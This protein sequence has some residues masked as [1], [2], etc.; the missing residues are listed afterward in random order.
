MN[1]TFDSTNFDRALRELARETRKSTAQI[2]REQAGLLAMDLMRAYPPFGGFLQKE[3]FAAQRRVGDAAT[4]KQIRSVYGIASDVYARLLAIDQRQAATYWH[5]H[6]NDPAAAADY[7]SGMML[8]ELTTERLDPAV[9]RRLRNRRGRVSDGTMRRGPH[10][11]VTIRERNRYIREKLQQVGKLKAGWLAAAM[12]YRAGR[13]VPGWIAR[14]GMRRSG[15]IDQADAKVASITLQNRV[16]YASGADPGMRIA[17]TVMRTRAD[18]MVKQ[19]MMTARANAR[20]ASR[21]AA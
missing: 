10:Q 12:R 1:I 9:H 16:T 20:R 17:I 21:R 19:A 5:L 7:L 13:G 15:L 14:H 11:V 18:L 3:N 4:R 6:I 2:L 8:T